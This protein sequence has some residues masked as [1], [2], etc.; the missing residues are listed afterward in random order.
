LKV[1]AEEIMQGKN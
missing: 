1:Q